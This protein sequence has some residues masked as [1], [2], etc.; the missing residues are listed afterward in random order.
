MLDFVEA[1]AMLGLL[2]LER[3]SVAGAMLHA[4]VDKSGYEDFLDRTQRFIDVEALGCFDQ[5][6]P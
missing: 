4:R 6:F 5:T 2:K 1:S 3:I